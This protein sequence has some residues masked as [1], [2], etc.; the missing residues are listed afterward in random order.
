[1]ISSSFSTSAYDWKINELFDL[2]SWVEIYE[3]ENIRLEPVNFTNPALQKTYDEFVVVDRQLKSVFTQKYNNR[4]ISYYEMHDLI[5]A[6]KSFIYS[7]SKTFSYI[8]DQQAWFAWPELDKALRI[9]YTNMRT[10]YARVF[11]IM[12]K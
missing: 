6:Y 1:V 3:L 7:T 5:K 10:S 8:A 2:R 4:E 12:N 11:H 9:S